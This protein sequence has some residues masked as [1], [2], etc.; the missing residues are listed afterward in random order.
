MHHI[1]HALPGDEAAFAER[2]LGI[3]RKF[4]REVRME[5][6]AAAVWA[7]SEGGVEGKEARFDI[8]QT[9]LAFGADIFLRQLHISRPLRG[10]HDEAVR[11]LERH[12]YR[13]A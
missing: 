3:D 10:E 13:L 6:E 8:G 1:L 11:E 9:D 7:G 5:A 4:R 2:Q 12:L